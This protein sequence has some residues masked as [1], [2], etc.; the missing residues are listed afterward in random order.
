M[1]L[2][3]NLWTFYND[4]ATGCDSGIFKTNNFSDLGKNSIFKRR[5]LHRGFNN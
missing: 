2:V 3:V 5:P 4:K 1:N